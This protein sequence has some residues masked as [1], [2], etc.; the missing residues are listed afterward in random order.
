MVAAATSFTITVPVTGSPAVNLTFSHDG[1][2]LQAFLVQR[3][4]TGSSD[5]WEQVVF[6]LPADVLVSGTDYSIPAVVEPDFTY[7]VVALDNDGS[8]NS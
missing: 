4:T 7:R 6:V 3:R 8:V 2:D 1:V 5:S